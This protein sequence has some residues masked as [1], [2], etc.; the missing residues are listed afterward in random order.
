MSESAQKWIKF[1]ISVLGL[2]VFL[3]CYIVLFKG[4]WNATNQPTANFL[5]LTSGFTGLVSG[6]VATMLGV[7]ISATCGG[8]NENKLTAMGSF[9]S[10][11]K[12]ARLKQALAVLYVVGYF[13]MAIWA[14]I[15]WIGPSD[16]YRPQIIDGLAAVGIGIAIAVGSGFLGNSKK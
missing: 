3:Y 6:V 5:Q 15:I 16:V 11:F 9:I 13:A 12:Y 8:G 2:I 1:F 14:I 7:K 4:E 10:P